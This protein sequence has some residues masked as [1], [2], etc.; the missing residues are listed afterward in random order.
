MSGEQTK[1]L[2]K[3]H[4]YTRG[5]AVES[6]FVATREEVESKIGQ[7]IYFG[8]IL[9][10]HSEVGGT[11]D[12]ED[13]TEI[14]EDQEFIEKFVELIGYTGYNPLYAMNCEDC[15]LDEDECKC[16]EE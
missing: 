5:G 10:K 8:E 15:G 9:G 13:L 6:Y 16:E 11:L 4:W 3:F 14:S 7:S 2:W 12:K 1:V